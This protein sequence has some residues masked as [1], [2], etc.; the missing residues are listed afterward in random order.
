MPPLDPYVCFSIL[1][2]DIGLRK[3]ISSELLI[4]VAMSVKNAPLGCSVS[5]VTK[6]DPGLVGHLEDHF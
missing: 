4:V 2:L 6:K 1:I 5:P 3:N